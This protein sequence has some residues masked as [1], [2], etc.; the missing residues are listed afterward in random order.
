MG[1]RAG[2]QGRNP[3]AEMDGGSAGSLA[4]SLCRPT[5]LQPK[6]ISAHSELDPLT[7]ILN[8]ANVPQA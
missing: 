7:L 5:G 1:V 2:T 4:C 6:S 3:E 8:Q